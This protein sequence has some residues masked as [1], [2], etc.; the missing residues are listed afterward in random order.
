MNKLLLPRSFGILN[1]FSFKKNLEI[2][3]LPNR[4]RSR[5]ENLKSMK[6]EEYDIM[7]IGGGATGAGVALEA[8]TRGL[9]CCLVEKGDFAG[10]TSGKSTK[11][12][13]GGVRYLDKAVH[14]EEV[15]ANLKL[16]F[17]ALN[18]RNT[19]I[20]SAPYMTSWVPLAIPCKNW[21][22]LFYFYAG[23]L[24]YQFIALSKNFSKSKIP[25]PRISFN[26]SCLPYLNKDFVGNVTYYDG[27]MNDT[28][29]CLE[30]LLTS[31]T[32]NYTNHSIPAHI[33]N[34][35]NFIEFIKQ[36]NK[37]VAAKVQDLN[38][39]DE[40]T[41]KS[42]VFVNC[43]GP[44]SDTIRKLGGMNEPRIIPGK[45]SHLILP[46]SYTPSNTGMLIPKTEDGRV[47]FLVPWE[48][49][50][51]L[52]TTD[53]LGKVTEH[54]AILD[55]EKEFLVKELSKYFDKSEKDIENDILGTFSGERPLVKSSTGKTSQLLRTHEVEV[56][57]SGLVSVLG[58]KWTTFRA[59]GEET[60][61]EIIK[62][63]KSVTKNP[64][65]TKDLTFYSNHTILNLENNLVSK[66]KIPL[67]TVQYLV[68]HYGTRADQV[69]ELGLNSIIDGYPFIE[70][71]VRFAVAKEYAL[72]PIDVIARR[73]RIALLNYNESV[74]AIEKV[75]RLMGSQ[76]H[77]S[78][79][80]I[81]T[82]IE[83]SKIEIK[84]FY[85]S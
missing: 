8:S 55:K 36:G 7:I 18:E 69:A 13:H 53:E 28:R 16:V 29:L 61:D 5:D 79:E 21:F 77:W 62:H 34:Y 43:T 4:I 11:L 33:S 40:F 75:A 63:F 56:S 52:G 41:I 68:Q 76:L 31:T 9:K 38:T 12:L 15:V 20:R 81:Q 80:T 48:N 39:G 3:Y 72:H 22:S 25:W 67:P 32:E 27:Q 23:L 57:E 17:E 42:K 51:I 14:G 54:S 1:G 30:A 84:Q 26:N 85:I 64:S 66:W 60:I 6:E 46:K 44:F 82:E 49:H 50:T 78:N 74:K 2:K 24:V 73:I 59:M 65:I 35:V 19:I 83:K 47:L 45:G 10:Q 70:G 58:G 37:I 71:E